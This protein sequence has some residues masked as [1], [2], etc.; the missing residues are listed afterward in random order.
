MTFLWD[1]ADEPAPAVRVKPRAVLR[2]RRG[3]LQVG[4]GGLGW[5]LLA[6]LWSFTQTSPYGGSLLGLALVL[7]L[8]VIAALESTVVILVACVRGSW[9]VALVSLALAATAIVVATR[10]ASQ[11]DYVDNQ[12]RI[13]RAALA[14]LAEDYRAGRLHDMLTVP[15]DLRSLCPSGFAYAGQE[16]LFVQ[17]WQNWRAESGTGLGYFT[18]PP[19]ADTLIATA[20]GD[21]GRPKREVGDGWWWVA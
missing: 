16:A 2:S 3:L 13:H 11:F 18:R 1:G 19:T 5:L 20:D 7:V 10:Q 12:Y 21:N 14:E 6:L 9:G 8:F 17:M 4:L 15:A